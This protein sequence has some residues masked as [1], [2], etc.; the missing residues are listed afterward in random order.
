MYVSFW[1]SF[2]CASMLCFVHFYHRKKQHI[3]KT[4]I[5]IYTKNLY[6]VLYFYDKF[7]LFFI[8]CSF[9]ITNKIFIFCFQ[10]YEKKR[11]KPKKSLFRVCVW[12]KHVYM[13]QEQK[14]HSALV[15]IIIII[16]LLHLHTN[17]S[18]SWKRNLTTYM[19]YFV[20]N[21]NITVKMLRF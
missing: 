4:I 10:K 9:V 16:F 21:E 3:Y 19:H 1:D 5:I 14:V 17:V 2:A 11:N 18:V 20:S 12:N 6:C 15:H 13:H 7:F 8:S